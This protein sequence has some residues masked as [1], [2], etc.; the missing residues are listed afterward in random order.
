MKDG[1]VGVC[2]NSKAEKAVDDKPAINIQ[3]EIDRLVKWNPN[4]NTNS[5]F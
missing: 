3:I 1:C 4:L 2:K 5:R